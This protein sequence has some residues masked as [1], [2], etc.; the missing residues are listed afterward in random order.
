MMFRKSYIK[1]Q[2][3]GYHWAPRWGSGDTR[4]PGPTSLCSSPPAPGGR[5]WPGSPPPHSPGGRRDTRAL[6]TG[7]APP[8]TPAPAVSSSSSSWS[9]CCS[10]TGGWPEHHSTAGGVLSKFYGLISIS[11]RG[12]GEGLRVVHWPCPPPHCRGAGAESGART[13]PVTAPAGAGLLGFISFK[14]V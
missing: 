8:P 11:G 12:V 3:S 14:T 6:G 4:G 2:S 10:L 9:P 7:T 1:I 5:P 13:I